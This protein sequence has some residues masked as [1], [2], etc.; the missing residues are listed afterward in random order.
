MEATM[1]SN[2]ASNLPAVFQ[3]EGKQVRTI[4]RDDQPWWVAKDVCSVLGYSNPRD[5]IKKHVDDDEKDGVAIR[6]A[7]GRMQNAPVI[8]QSG[9]YTL[10]LRSRMP[11]AKAFKRW[12]TRE[13]LPA[14]M[15]T[16]R[17]EHP[18]ARFV[19]PYEDTHI[20]ER[21]PGLKD[22]SEK[23][24]ALLESHVALLESRRRRRVPVTDPRQT[25]IPLLVKEGAG[26]DFS[27][28]PAAPAPEPKKQRERRYHLTKH[29]RAKIR[30][31]KRLDPKKSAADIA[32]I[33]GR[34]P[35]AVRR[36]LRGMRRQS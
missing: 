13:V 22:W 33:V 20:E 8:N 18:Q 25:S 31:I 28:H 23:Y 35:D 17:Y 36:A 12:V 5:A 34:G 24:I 9:L 2:T 14:I 4:V 15:R 19:K 16:G 3:F 6:D 27:K 1:T 29:E 26:E 21:M 32:A 11:Q 10:I 7:T 30:M